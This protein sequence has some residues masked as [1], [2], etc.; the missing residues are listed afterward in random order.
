MGYNKDPKYM[1]GLKSVSGEFKYTIGDEGEYYV[2]HVH[3][4][5]RVNDVID[6]L[7]NAINT[8]NTTRDDIK[9]MISAYVLEDEVSL[10][11]L[12]DY[13]TGGMS[14]AL[15]NISD[16]T[17][18]ALNEMVEKI[19]VRLSKDNDTNIIF[20]AED[21]FVIDNVI[22]DYIVDFVCVEKK[23]IVEVD[24][25][26]HSEYE[27]IEKDEHRTEKL[28][29]MGFNVIRFANEEI[30]ANIELVISKIKEQFIK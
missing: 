17:Q 16:K 24:G 1:T 21:F 9:N 15:Q 11:Q 22:N 20:D 18:E 25:G 7:T 3:G 6:S 28:K 26:Y 8:Y 10:N 5:D 23:L 12:L 29:G 27:Q 13:V 14:E 30:F 4:Y 19:R 2:D